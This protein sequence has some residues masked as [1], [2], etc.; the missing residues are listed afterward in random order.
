MHCVSDAESFYCAL[1]RVHQKL[2][3]TESRNGASFGALFGSA[4]Q[5]GIISRRRV[6]YEAVKY[7]KERTAGF[8]SPFGYSTASVAAAIDT[9][10]ALEVLQQ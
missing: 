6:Y 5:L 1:P 9:V 4:L 7:E 10:C 8:L 3:E 2:R